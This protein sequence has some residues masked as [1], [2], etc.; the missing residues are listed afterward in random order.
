MNWSVGD[1][2]G[3][4]GRQYELIYFAHKGRRLLG[5]GKRY[6][7]ILR[8]SRGSGADYE[9][10][11][12]KP[13]EIIAR[14]VEC[15]SKEGEVVLDPFLGSG[16]TAVV[17]EKMNRQWLGCEIEPQYWPVIESRLGAERVQGRLF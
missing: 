4:Y 16:T 7:N 17:A 9:H 3:D 6:G 14:L 13:E 11:T 12:Q 1:L 15:S 8:A 10:P 2:E 5:G